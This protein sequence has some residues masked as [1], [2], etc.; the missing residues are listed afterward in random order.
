MDLGFVMV[1]DSASS[2]I[3]RQ[4]STKLVIEHVLRHGPISRA[5]IA[6]ATGLSKQTISD[7][8]RE[9]ERD[10]WVREQGQVQGA[11]G[12]S[13]V[14]YSIRP[15]AAFVLGID[16]GGTKLH[17]A[18]ADLHGQI[19]AELIEP[20]AREGGAAVVE[21]IGR[22]TDMLVERAGI[23]RE[24]LRGGVMGSPGVIDPLSGGIGIA[25]NIP[26]LDRLDVQGALR[27]RL[28]VEVA[29]ENDVN[30]AAIGEHWCGG[31]KGANTFVFVALGTGIGMGIFADGRLLRGARG[32]AGEIAYLPVGGDPY[33]ARGQR[34]G[35][36]ESAIGSAAITER[37]AGLGGRD[38][39][40]VR[41]IF[42]R[43][44]HD[45]KARAT[46]DEVAR[47]IA[48]AILAVHSVIDPEIVVMGGSIGVRPELIERI[49]VHLRNCMGQPARIEVSALGSRATL[50]GAIGSAIDLVHRALFGVGAGASLLALPSL[51]AGVAA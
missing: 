41:E 18:L 40:T 31:S 5:E 36:L 47:L 28:G 21:Q 7:V 39:H 13:A 22:L 23:A 26:G 20:T 6:R 9:L 49:A 51:G 25:P 8:M 15:E 24:R 19:A 1:P 10:G 2:T 12:R 44:G 34:L 43:F 16:L 14:T 50:I 27:T 38:A 42:D 11:L 17:L 46:I 48:T 30:L 45:E 35:T 3:V 32:A 4:A 33:D 29:V 37:Y